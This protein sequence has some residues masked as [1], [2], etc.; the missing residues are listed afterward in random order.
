MYYYIDMLFDSNTKL[1]VVLA[2][3]LGLMYM[4][5]KSNAISNE[6][7]LEKLDDVDKLLDDDKSDDLDNVLNDDKLDDDE[8]DL[9]GTELQID[10]VLKETGDNKAKSDE[11]PD[12]TVQPYDNLPGI[13]RTSGILGNDWGENPNITQTKMQQLMVENDKNKLKLNASDLL[14]KEVNNNWFETDLSQAELK[15]DNAN[16]V[17]TD[18][19]VIGVNTVGQSLKNPS[20]DLRSAPACPKITVSPWNQST[21]EPDYNIKSLCL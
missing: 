7:K 18:R 3:I 15:V 16:L 12:D 17:V 13:A 4:C 10:D 14:P 8:D 19:Y 5:N 21:I 20:Y 6:G 2:I 11:V 9:T 1:L